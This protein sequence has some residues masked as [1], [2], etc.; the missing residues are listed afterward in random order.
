MGFLAEQGGLNSLQGRREGLE[1][2]PTLRKPLRKGTGWE[3]VWP[4]NKCT[5]SRGSA[6]LVLLGTLSWGALFHSPGVR[7]MAA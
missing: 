3:T 2:V 6:L 4:V 7:S 1:G 5:P